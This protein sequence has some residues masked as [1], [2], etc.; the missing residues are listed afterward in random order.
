MGQWDRVG[1]WRKYV[2]LDRHEEHQKLS[3][4]E[5]Y[6]ELGRGEQYVKLC[7]E[8][9]YQEL[10]HDEKYVKLSRHTNKKYGSR[11]KVC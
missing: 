2:E 1:S 10:E 5:R 8:E 3:H 9:R 11:R 7:C 4:D 6:V